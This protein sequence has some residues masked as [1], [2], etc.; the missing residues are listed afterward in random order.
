MKTSSSCDTSTKQY[1]NNMYDEC[2]EGILFTFALDGEV[3]I[4]WFQWEKQLTVNNKEQL[5]KGEDSGT[6]DD[7]ITKLKSQ[8]PFFIFLHSV[9]FICL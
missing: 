1:W 9:K 2:K 5:Q 7:A 4:K 6:F 8:I 3:S